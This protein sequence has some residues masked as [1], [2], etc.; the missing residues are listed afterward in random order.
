ML[1][2][3]DVLC[4]CVAETLLGLKGTKKLVML[5]PFC[6]APC[7]TPCPFDFSILLH[8]LI[9]AL[10]YCRY[11]MFTHN[12][13]WLVVS[14]DWSSTWDTCLPPTAFLPS[15]F[16]FSCSLLQ[17]LKR[18]LFS[19]CWLGS[20]VLNFFLSWLAPEHTHTDLL[21]IAQEDSCPKGRLLTYH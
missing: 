16:C 20:W 15:L 10:P 21:L 5:V 8:S 18:H 19:F 1:D 3:V 4:L 12:R 17:L 14:W 13:G 9:L 6:S 7:Y 2:N 11:P